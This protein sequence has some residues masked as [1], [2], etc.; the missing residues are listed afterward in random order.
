MQEPRSVPVLAPAGGI[1]RIERD[2]AL[3]TTKRRARREARVEIAEAMVDD[4][5]EA[6]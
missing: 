5:A 2:A 1:K 3:R 4:V 6:T